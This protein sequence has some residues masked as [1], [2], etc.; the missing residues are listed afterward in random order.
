MRARN[1]TPR[2][3]EFK[4]SLRSAR[5]A[6][7]L[8]P[9]RHSSYS[10][11]EGFLLIGL[12]A[13]KQQSEEGSGN[14]LD[15]SKEREESSVY[16]AGYVI[17]K[18]TKRLNCEHCSASLASS[19]ASCRLIQM[20]N[21]S[22]S[23]LSLASPSAGVVEVIK[24][25]E[26]FFRANREEL[27]SNHVSPS[28]VDHTSEYFRANIFFASSH[29]ILPEVVSMFLRVRMQISV[30]TETSQIAHNAAHSKYGS[31]SIGM[32]AAVS[33]IW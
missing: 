15:L 32:R 30:P 6:Q 22:M 33:R 28:A 16:L 13:E 19:D 25:A 3:Y 26:N 17:S 8:K 4:C 12:N 27:L 23:H 21:Y 1:P 18:I 24:V 14:I 31:K 11:D 2:L 5:L 20:K 29:N 10:D 9:S 7:F